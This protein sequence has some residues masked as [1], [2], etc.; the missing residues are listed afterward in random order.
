MR[1]ATKDLV[2][3]RLTSRLALSQMPEPVEGQAQQAALEFIVCLVVLGII[4][5]GCLLAW[6]LGGQP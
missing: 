6:V 2:L 1:Q 4:A 3:D 5:T